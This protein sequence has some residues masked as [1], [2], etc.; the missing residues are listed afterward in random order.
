[1]PKYRKRPVEI[2]AFC[3]GPE[4][5]DVPPKWFTKAYR[6]GLI[7]VEKDKDPQPYLTGTT[8]ADKQ[9]SYLIIYTLEGPMKANQ[10]DYII[11]GVQGELYPCKPDIFKMTYEKVE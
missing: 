7:K 4:S 6:A 8:K 10:G 5:E 11:Q 3:W 1:M 9:A 2:E